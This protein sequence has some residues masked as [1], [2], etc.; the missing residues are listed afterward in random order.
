MSKQH[1]CNCNCLYGN[2]HKNHILCYQH[3]IMCNCKN[4]DKKKC[5]KCVLSKNNDTTAP[6]NCNLNIENSNNSVVLTEEY[7]DSHLVETKEEISNNNIISNTKSCKLI[8]KL[9]VKLIMKLIVKF[10]VKF[11][12]LIVKLIMIKCI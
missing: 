8:V 7:K 1:K 4:N 12:K 3:S 11:V 10:I 5:K 9:I 2:S 6:C